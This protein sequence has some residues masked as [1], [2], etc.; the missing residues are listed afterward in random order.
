[1]KFKVKYWLRISLLNL[2]IVALLGGLMRYKIGF[3]FPLFSQKNIQHA[4]SHFAFSGWVTHTL[5]VLM[6]R[7]IYNKGALFQKEYS[8][9]L[10]VNL[11]C[12]Y[13]MLFSFFAQGYGAISI[14]F[15]TLTIVNSCFFTFYFIRDL[16]KIKGNTSS[17]AWFKS[18][19]WFNVV[20][21]LGT[22]YLAYMLTSHNFNEN[23]YLAAIYFYLHFQYNGFFI[24]ACLGLLIDEAIILFPN[25]KYDKQIFRLFFVSVIPAYFLSIIWANLPD[26]LYLIVVIAAFI[27]VF[28][29]VKF[30]FLIRKSTLNNISISKFSKYLFLFVAIAYTAKILLQLGSTIPTLSTL[31]FGFRPV[32]IAY[33]HLVLLAVV[34]VFLLAFLYTFNL[35]KKSK[36]TVTALIIFI[37]GVFLNE[38][39]L[40]IQGVAAFKYLIIPNVNEALF[41]VAI[42]ITL[43]LIALVI[44][45]RN[46]ELK[47]E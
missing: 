32:V 41:V 4:H 34:S 1:M 15:S 35:I 23:Y 19:L 12:S 2:L 20:S 6:I 22:F 3:E 42:L 5:Y 24:F 27:Q 16:N 44:S 29:W 45:Q 11:V 36:L 21:S 17:N 14:I 31:A 37:I 28:V 38:L 39:L 7:F 47:L 30:V 9:L 33:L 26:W 43:S 10:I 18:A 13:G 40:A 8:I 46:T 25:F